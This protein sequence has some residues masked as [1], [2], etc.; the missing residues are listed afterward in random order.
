MDLKLL[1]HTVFS[2]RCKKILFK[3]ELGGKMII[4]VCNDETG[5]KSS[6]EVDFD[7]CSS[8]DIVLSI[9]KCIEL[10]QSTDPQAPYPDSEDEA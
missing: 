1:L 3:Y 4:T 8:A 10:S 7:N 5:Q 2:F 6:V 9:T